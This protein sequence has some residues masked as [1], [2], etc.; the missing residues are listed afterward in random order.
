MQRLIDER[1]QVV[2]PGHG[3]IGGPQLL[4]D[5]RYYLEEL[6][7]AIQRESL[8]RTRRRVRSESSGTR[9]LSASNSS[10]VS[11]RL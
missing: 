5:V 2:V 10:K 4:A 3:D 6:R 1:P 8:S 11:M 7:V 9:A